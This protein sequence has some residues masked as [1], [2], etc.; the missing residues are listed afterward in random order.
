L[1]AVR[2]CSPS[3]RE[4]SSSQFRIRK[5]ARDEGKTDSAVIFGIPYIVNI[6]KEL[7]FW[8]PSGKLSSLSQ[9]KIAK[10]LREDRLFSRFDSDLRLLI[11]VI[12]SF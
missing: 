10:C 12:D 3:D 9:Y 7:R 2:Y 5:V 1:S 8:T 4:V 11:F 6:S